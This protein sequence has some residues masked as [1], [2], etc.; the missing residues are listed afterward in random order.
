M[1]AEPKPSE[2]HEGHR[3]R[4]KQKFYEDGF[5]GFNDHE[6]LEL[7]LFY[8][9]PRRDTNGIAHKLLNTFG[10]ISSVF[11][12]PIEALMDAGLSENAA[13]MLKTVM[14]VSRIY[15]NDKF[16]NDKKFYDRNYL[17]Q[18]FITAFIGLAEEHVMIAMFDKKGRELYFGEV[19]KGSFNISE[20]NNRRIVELAMKY[21]A[22]G[23][24]IAHNHPSGVAH[25]SPADIETT[26][27]LHRSL[28]SVGVSLIDH[29]IVAET[30]SVS[31]SND[32]QLME[33]FINPD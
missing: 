5:K 2:L 1:S 24:V 15:I 27:T 25:P 17:R 4:L 33:I 8:A 9:I 21:K 11:D 23:V 13:L 19:S 16:Y 14:Q 30:N 6:I 31:L 10:S 7:L 28:R 32:E 22:S 3:K 20:I 29:I 26:I 18:K 12:A